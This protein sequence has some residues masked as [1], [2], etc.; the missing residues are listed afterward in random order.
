MAEDSDSGTDLPK[1]W[2]WY[3]EAI[4]WFIAIAAGLLTFGFDRAAKGEMS[5][6]SW[7]IYLGGSAALGLS[8]ISGL[9]AY[10]QL[11]GAANL[12]ERKTTNSR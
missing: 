7:Y 8:S 6:I 2:G 12:Y 5:G 1:T 3:G 11:L 4:K 10:L 9:F